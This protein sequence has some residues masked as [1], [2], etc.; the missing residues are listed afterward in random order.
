M[1]VVAC[2]VNG[3]GL[4]NNLFVSVHN[5]TIEVEP[6]IWNIWIWFG[7]HPICS[8]QSDPQLTTQ[9]LFW[10]KKVPQMDGLAYHLRRVCLATPTCHG[11]H[12][13][14]DSLQRVHHGVC[15]WLYLYNYSYHD[16]HHYGLSLL[17]CLPTIN[18]YIY[19]Y[20]Y[21]YMYIYIYIYVGI[22]FV[23]LSCIDDHWYY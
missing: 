16:Y 2:Q 18:K 12:K 9:Q 8:L 10:S 3:M 14:L 19:I 21:M 20:M 4:K 22:I 1:P 5:G 7:D 15:I 23:V 13:Q 11:S 6:P 17:L